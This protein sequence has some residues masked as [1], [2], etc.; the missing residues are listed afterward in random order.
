MIPSSVQVEELRRY[1]AEHGRT[2]RAQLLSDWEAGRTVGPLQELRNQF[3]P[4]WLHQHGAQA[5]KPSTATA[6]AAKACPACGA[7]LELVK[8]SEGGMI[9]EPY[10]PKYPLRD[11]PLPRRRRPSNFLACPACEH[12][13]EV[14]AVK[15]KWFV[16][17]VERGAE[18]KVVKRIEAGASERA[19]EKVERGVNINLNTARFFTRV[20]EEAPDQVAA[21]YLVEVE[22]AHFSFRACGRTEAEARAALAAGWKKHV[23]QSGAD[24]DHLDPQEEGNVLVL[25]PGACYRDGQELT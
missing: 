14:E 12:C 24:P 20:V 23:E 4:S 9:E 13:E 15:L 16:E 25:R 19:A 11:A 6:P 18:E 1:A 7:T 3:G 21:L 22:T 8:A 17:V 5:I 2:W 10:F